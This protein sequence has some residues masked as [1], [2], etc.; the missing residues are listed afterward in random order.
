[1][2]RAQVFCHE[3]TIRKLWRAYGS[4]WEFVTQWFSSTQ[5]L[6]NSWYNQNLVSCDVSNVY[7]CLTWYIATHNILTNFKKFLNNIT[8]NEEGK[9]LYQNVHL[10]L[11]NNTFNGIKL[12]TKKLYR[13]F[14][15]VLKKALLEFKSL[16]F[17]KI[18]KFYWTQNLGQ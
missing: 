7:G 17:L 14:A 18:L 4:P 9:P 13:E 8:V 6:W 15:L 1:M 5:A 16:P 3:E 10:K 2:D 11:Y 12:T